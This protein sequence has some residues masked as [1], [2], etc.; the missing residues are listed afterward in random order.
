MC[1]YSTKC[2]ISLPLPSFLHLVM[3]LLPALRDQMLPHLS[4]LLRIA[5][6]LTGQASELLYT[7]HT[8]TACSNVLVDVAHINNVDRAESLVVM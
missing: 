2:V 1:C 7:R 5:L 6:L 4:K 8:V 3:H